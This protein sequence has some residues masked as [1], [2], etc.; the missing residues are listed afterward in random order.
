MKHELGTVIAR[1]DYFSARNES[2]ASIVKLEIGMPAKSPHADDEYMC[3]FRLKA[4]GSECTETVYGT[5]ELQALQLALGYAEAKLRAFS[6]SADF[7]LH[8]AGGEDGDLGI[9]IPAFS[10]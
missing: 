1:R 10:N 6:N 3:S 8:W 5:D 2:A 9:R 4:P 7:H